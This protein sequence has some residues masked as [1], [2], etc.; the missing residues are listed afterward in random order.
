MSRPASRSAS[1]AKEEETDKKEEEQVDKEIEKGD[2]SSDSEGCVS[3]LGWLGRSMMGAQP[4][5]LLAPRPCMCLP[6]SR[7]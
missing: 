7:G 4:A 5:A 3:R 2:A 6:I 1:P